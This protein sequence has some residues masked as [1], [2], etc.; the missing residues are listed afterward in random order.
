MEER[1]IIPD[2]SPN[3][4]L[5]APYVDNAN[6]VACSRYRCDAVLAGVREE[7]GA[8]RLVYHEVVEAATRLATDRVVL[9]FKN[10][11]LMYAKER[12]YRLDLG[13]YLVGGGHM[14]YWSRHANL[15]GAHRAHVVITARRADRGALCVAVHHGHRI[16]LCRRRDGQHAAADAGHGGR[17]ADAGAA[18]RSRG[19]DARDTRHLLDGALGALTCQNGAEKAC[20]ELDQGPGEGRPGGHRLT[21]DVDHPCMGAA[22][23][24]RLDMRQLL[25]IEWGRRRTF[26]VNVGLAH[27]MSLPGSNCVMRS[28]PTIYVRTRA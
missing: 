2:I 17:H 11:T 14:Y 25:P 24:V 13:M 21:A 6:L 27:L 10:R 12:S 9:D 28:P 18:G 1:E 8:R 22:P 19:Q 20:R 26:V 23:G 5:C 15:F 4:A 16:R 7:F 3:A